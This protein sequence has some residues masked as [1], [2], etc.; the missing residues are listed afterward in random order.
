[1]TLDAAHL[2]EYLVW[3]HIA[4]GSVG[5]AT[6]WPPVL[7]RKG[8]PFHKACGK[9]FWGALLATGA[10]AVGIST[11]SLLAPLE[12]HPFTDDAAFVRGM[13]GWMML[14][15]AVMT[16]NLAWYGRVI[17][18]NR[19]NHPANRTLLVFL[20]QAATFVTAV[21]CAWQGFRI[22]QPLMV[23]MS[24]VGLAASVLNTQFLLRR[25]P[26]WNEWLIQHS[27]GLVGAG[28]SVYTAFL[29]FGLVNSVPSLALNPALWAVP[30]TLGV[31]YLLWHQ[32]RIVRER[33]RRAAGRAATMGAPQ[34]TASA[35]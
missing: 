1:M 33:R 28:I 8:T 23:G 34:G 18:Q 4:T 21:N 19:R 10:I 15:L 6:L 14:Y 24:V 27:R 20:L 26:P 22:G 32:F 30:C 2:F 5:L 11:C 12:T 16:V 13:F 35:G 7:G 25:D 3:A 17:V 29:A 31:A 9:V